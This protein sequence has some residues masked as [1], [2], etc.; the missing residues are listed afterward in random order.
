MRMWMITHHLLCRQ[1]LLGEHNELHKHLPSF[2]KH[3]SMKGR[4]GQIEP[5]K[6]KE[7]HDDLVDEMISRGYKH[8]SPYEIPDLSYLTEKE[9]QSKVDVGKSME[10][11]KKRCKE[12]KKR[13]EEVK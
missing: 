3:H 1:H 2:L 6:M 9:I 11:L 7:R 5:L 12:C 13:I 8:N 4:I 10:L